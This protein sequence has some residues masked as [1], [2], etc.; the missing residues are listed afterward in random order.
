MDYDLKHLNSINTTSSTLL[1]SNVINSSKNNDNNTNYKNKKILL[2]NKYVPPKRKPMS[3]PE[4]NIFNRNKIRKDIFG[5]EIKKG[6]KQKVSFIDLIAVIEDI[7][8]NEINHYNNNNTSNQN[9]TSNN[10]EEDKKKN[11]LVEIIEVESYKKQ[12]KNMVYKGN[13]EENINCCKCYL[14]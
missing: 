1:K 10:I 9:N 2:I 5:E 11:D 4:L 3:T 7:N 14:I 13:E 12:N 8:E 6:G